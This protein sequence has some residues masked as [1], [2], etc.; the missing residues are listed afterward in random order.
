MQFSRFG[1]ATRRASRRWRLKA[2]SLSLARSLSRRRALRFSLFVALSEGI[3]FIVHSV[4]VY[5][6]AI[7]NGSP[8][9]LD[10]S[11]TAEDLFLN[12]PSVRERASDKLAGG[13]N[14]D[15]RAG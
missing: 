2:P 13:F 9:Q 6:R 10:Q 4:A 7:N 12:C 1:L 3:D 5:I 11:P 15:R 14:D 8:R